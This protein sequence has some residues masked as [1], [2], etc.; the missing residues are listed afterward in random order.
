MNTNIQMIYSGITIEYREESNRWFFEVNGRE[1]SADSLTKA[2]E[3]ID[4]PER[5]KPVKPFARTKAYLMH[6]YSGDAYQVVDVT[7]IAE[8]GY[9]TGVHFWVSVNGQRKKE[10]GYALVEVTEA[11]TRVIE[12][13]KQLRAQ[14]E[15]LRAQVR[16]FEQSLPKMDDQNKLATI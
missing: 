2:K 5:E 13:C 15:A 7:S 9:S 3:S 12:A 6:S 14:E 4:R 1:R 11:S 10:S 16:D 8:R